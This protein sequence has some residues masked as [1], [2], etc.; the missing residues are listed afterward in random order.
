MSEIEDEL[1]MLMRNLFRSAFGNRFYRVVI[2]GFRNHKTG[3]VIQSAVLMGN[4]Y[5]SYIQ[6]IHI[7]KINPFITFKNRS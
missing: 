6:N 1:L 3:M 4:L 2:M 5:F 7:Q